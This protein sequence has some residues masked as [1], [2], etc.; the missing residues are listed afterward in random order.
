[1]VLRGSWTQQLVSQNQKGVDEVPLRELMVCSMML[2][3]QT[4]MWAAH[5][6]L[7]LQRLVALALKRAGTDLLVAFCVALVAMKA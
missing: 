4:L 2:A 6:V 7:G 3:S 1:M 5:W